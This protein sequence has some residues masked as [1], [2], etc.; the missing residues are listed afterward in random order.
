M[1]FVSCGIFFRAKLSRVQIFEESNV[2]LFLIAFRISARVCSGSCFSVL[3]GLKTCV[4]DWN[5][6]SL[7]LWYLRNPWQ[8]F[9]AG[10]MF[11]LWNRFNIAR[12]WQ[13]YVSKNIFTRNVFILQVQF[14]FSKIN[15]HLPRCTTTA[16]TPCTYNTFHHVYSYQT[17]VFIFTTLFTFT[18]IST[19]II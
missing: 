13:F 12:F 11:D 2:L 5:N 17:V 16:R 8:F 4:N 3:M 15:R 14:V 9:C 1:G 10:Q 18:F 19:V 7:Y 6:L